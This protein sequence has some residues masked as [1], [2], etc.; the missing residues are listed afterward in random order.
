MPS[1]KATDHYN[2]GRLAPLIDKLGPESQLQIL[3]VK[4]AE[5][6]YPTLL[7]LHFPNTSAGSAI[8]SKIMGMKKG[9]P[10]LQIIAPDGNII[11]VEFKTEIGTVSPEQKQMHKKLSSY[12]QQ[13]F[14]L[15]T[16]EEWQSFLENYFAEYKLFYTNK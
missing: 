10:D 13:V 16:L 11:F 3:C 8:V 6:N 14:I 12:Y 15:R 2:F 9:F 7:L 5:Q 4:Y 1:N